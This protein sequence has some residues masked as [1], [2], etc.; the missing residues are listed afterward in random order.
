M[1]T[2]NEVKQDMAKLFKKLDELEVEARLINSVRWNDRYE[3]QNK[4][5]G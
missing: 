4:E 5:R 1:R 3:V 2:I